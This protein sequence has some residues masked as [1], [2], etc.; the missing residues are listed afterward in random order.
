M[1]E[2]G[3]LGNSNTPDSRVL[4]IAPGTHALIWRDDSSAAELRMDLSLSVQM[5]DRTA[6]LLFEFPKLYLKKNLPLVD[7]LG[8]PGWQE[9][10]EG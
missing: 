7:K 4:G 5:R 3:D 1:Y 9:T 6:R 10:A 8:K 2:W